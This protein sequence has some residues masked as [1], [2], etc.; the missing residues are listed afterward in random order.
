M[1]P[2]TDQIDDYEN[3][4]DTIA[5]FI[6]ALQKNFKEDTN[7]TYPLM[8]PQAN[9]LFVLDGDIADK[10]KTYFKSL[11]VQ[12]CGFVDKEFALT[13]RHN[14]EVG[15]LHR[16]RLEFNEGMSFEMM[17]RLREQIPTLEERIV[18]RRLAH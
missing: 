3:C 6:D 16:I 17:R 11:I 12:H 2:S 1:S 4:F 9:V 14:N 18:Q 8:P 10:M 5:R 15:G 7:Y 13:V